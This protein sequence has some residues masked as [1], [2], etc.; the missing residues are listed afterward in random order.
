[1]AKQFTATT[2][3]GLMYDEFM[4]IDEK[5][6]QII[7]KA[8]CG[9]IEDTLADMDYLKN[10]DHEG[11]QAFYN[12]QPGGE[13]E[14][15]L[16]RNTNY[17]GNHLCDLFNVDFDGQV[18]LISN[19]K[20]V[21]GAGGK[22]YN[23]FED[24]LWNGFGPYNVKKVTILPGGMQKRMM[25]KEMWAYR[26]R[27]K[28]GRN[29]VKKERTMF[30]DKLMTY[31]YRYAGKWFYKQK[32]LDRMDST[33]ITKF[34]KYIMDSVEIGIKKSMELVVPDVTT[35]FEYFGGINT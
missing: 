11:E 16:K 4:A 3:L 23:L 33:L 18:F 28:A 7:L 8:A 26:R 2:H 15:T 19:S 5:T 27:T 14:P 1:M 30:E 29:Q 22:N 31:H 20:Y 24:L 32:K 6:Q 34:R 9:E 21:S 12:D 17:G 13:S 35:T 10:F 25:G